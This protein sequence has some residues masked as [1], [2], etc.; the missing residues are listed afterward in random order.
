MRLFIFSVCLIITHSGYSQKQ[1]DPRVLFKIAPLALIDDVS[2]PTIQGGVEVALNPRIS[3]YNEFGIRYMNGGKE[4]VDTSFVSPRGFKLKSEVRYYWQGRNDE[5][6]NWLRGHYVAINFYYTRCVSNSG[7]SYYYQN[8]SSNIV[9]DNFGVTKSIWGT[10]VII[11]RQTTLGKRFLFDIYA[12]LG[13]RIRN[14]VTV[15]KEFD[16]ERD[17]IKGPID[18]NVYSISRKAEAEAGKSGTVN[19]SFG[20]RFAYRLY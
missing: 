2:F 17:E 5:Y 16:P 11:G 19:I 14:F 18:L 7:I 1:R 13:I 10:N 15:N 6:G 8:D 9:K 3:L 20:I 4:N 12:G